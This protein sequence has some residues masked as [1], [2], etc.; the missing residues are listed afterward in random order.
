MTLSSLFEILRL[1]ILHVWT[2]SIHLEDLKCFQTAMLSSSAIVI[3]LARSWKRNS[4]QNLTSSDIYVR[5]STWENTIFNT[6][7]VMRAI[8]R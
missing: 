6:L 8:R 1:F 7:M 3:S 5:S 2:F 4:K